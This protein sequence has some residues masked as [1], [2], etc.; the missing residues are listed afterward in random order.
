M[1]VSKNSSHARKEQVKWLLY[2][3]AKDKTPVTISSI[4]EEVGVKPGTLHGYVKSLEAEANMQYMNLEGFKKR[5]ILR[6]AVKHY[7][8]LRKGEK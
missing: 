1:R 4:C 3:S 5:N 2:N 7:H 8:E 6:L